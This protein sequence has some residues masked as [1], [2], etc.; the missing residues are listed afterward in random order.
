METEPTVHNLGVLPTTDFQ[1]TYSW[2]SNL[3]D[4]YG[5]TEE[6][7]DILLQVQKF[8]CAI[9]GQLPVKKRLAVGH[10]HDTGRV[11]GLLCHNCNTGLGMFKDSPAR[12]LRAIKYLT[13][14]RSEGNS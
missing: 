4:K 14:D 2:R 12:L 10:D 6:Q 11:R 9:C 5:I 1:H 13:R 8:K 7:Y 3:Q